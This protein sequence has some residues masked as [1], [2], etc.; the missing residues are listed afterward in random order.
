M[1]LCHSIPRRCLHISWVHREQLEGTFY[2]YILYSS[3]K[4]VLRLSY[5]YSSVN[6]IFN[7]HIGESAKSFWYTIMHTVC[8]E[9][10]EQPP[11][12]LLV[13]FGRYCIKTADLNGGKFKLMITL[14]YPIEMQFLGQVFIYNLLVLSCSPLDFSLLLLSHCLCTYVTAIYNTKSLWY[15]FLEKFNKLLVGILQKSLLQWCVESYVCVR[16]FLQS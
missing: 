8:F 12:V 4:R 15:S 14:C 16:L 9:I 3:A 7:G 13:S 10:C 6:G 5:V 2:I 11:A 1:N